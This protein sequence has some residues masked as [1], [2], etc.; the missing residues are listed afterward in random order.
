MPNSAVRSDDYVEYCRQTAKHARDPHDLALR[1]RHKKEVRKLV[2][3]QIAEAVDL[4][5]GD[6]L[7]DIGCG[8]GTL[9]R[10]ANAAGADSAIGLLAT[11]EE[12]PC[13]AASALTPNQGLTNQPSSTR[14]QRL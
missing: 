7:V 2:R 4:R 3:Q 11:D 12:S 10:I 5:A 1:G 13:S 14:L 8:D 6:D 9:L